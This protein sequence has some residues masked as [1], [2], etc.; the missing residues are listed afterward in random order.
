VFDGE[1]I[2]K[3]FNKINQQSEDLVRELDV[4]KQQIHQ[5]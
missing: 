2:I 1:D 4:K 3:Q 5:A